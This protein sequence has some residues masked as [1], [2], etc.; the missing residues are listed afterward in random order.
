M[1]K[2]FWTIFSLDAPDGY[3]L[4]R[5]TADIDTLLLDK[6]GVAK[7]RLS[8]QARVMSADS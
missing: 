5:L 7:C 6:G 8:F 2:W 1:F 3:I 4:G